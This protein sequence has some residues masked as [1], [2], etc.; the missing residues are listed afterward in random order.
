MRSCA[1]PARA[2]AGVV[3]TATLLAGC[4]SQF[5]ADPYAENANRAPIDIL[6]DA[7][8]TDQLVLAEIFRQELIGQGREASIMTEDIFQETKAGRSLNQRGNFYVG[9][10]GAFLGVLNPGEARE[11]SKV[12]RK[13]QQASQ[14]GGEDYLARTHIA[15]MSSLPS[16]LSTVEPSGATGC[17]DATPELPENFVVFYQDELF[18]RE[19]RQSVASLTKFITQ[20]DIS[21]M[22]EKAEQ[23][24]D[25][26]KVVRTW[27][28]DSGIKILNEE[29]DS[30][31]SGGSDLTGG[32]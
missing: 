20:K 13:A 19:E 24:G 26:E 31:S 11:I 7:N 18:D 32:S 4:S 29:G 1:R 27:L 12:Y 22:A 23:K 15:L 21:E 30:D 6:V 25:V 2:I 3:L 5:D 14:P 17:E 8:E 9:C 10:T 16:D 28:H